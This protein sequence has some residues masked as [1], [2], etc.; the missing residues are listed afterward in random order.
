MV[1]EILLVIDGD[2][3]AMIQIE[4]KLTR[5]EASQLFERN[6]EGLAILKDSRFQ[7]IDNLG[8]I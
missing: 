3:E 1:R 5:D 8:N 2:D 7:G 6:V 4:G